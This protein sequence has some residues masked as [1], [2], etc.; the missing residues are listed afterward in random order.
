MF[1]LPDFA[2]VPVRAISETATYD[3]CSAR[4]VEIPACGKVVIL[5]DLALRTPH[6]SYARRAPRSGLA[7][8]K[9]LGVGKG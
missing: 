3:M 6:V 8:K 2:Q 1:R 7:V 5:T 4:N 9:H